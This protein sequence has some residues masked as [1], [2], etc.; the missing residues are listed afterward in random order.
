MYFSD[1]QR[2]L[3]KSPLG[4]VYV[5]YGNN[6][7]EIQETV[8]VLKARAARDDDPAL[9]VVE[10]TKEQRDLADV[11]DALLSVPMFVSSRMVVLQN[12]GDFLNRHRKA[13]EN[14]LE[15]PCE[16]S[17]LVMTVEKWNRKTKLSQRIE[18]LGGDVACWTPRGSQDLIAWV[19]RRAR[20][21]HSKQMD[22]AAAQLLADLCQGDLSGIA[23]ELAKLELYVGTAEAVTEADVSAVGMGYSA[24]R[25]FD[26]CDTLADGNRAAA[27]GVV[28]A[29]MA[30]GLPPPVLVG[31]LRSTFRRLLDTRLAADRDGMTAAVAKHAWNPRDR[32]D[33]RRRVE[34]F[35]ADR[36]VAAYRRLL[37]ADL[38]AKTSRYPDR[39]IVERLLL[40][41][42][43]QALSA[44]GT[45]EVR[46]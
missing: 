31:A 25:P 42:S 22:A 39:L 23:A 29:L 34:R 6:T 37:V 41:L 8:A 18:Q 24:Y 9:A 7:F 38:E 17:V 21:V 28:E 45:D 30:E 26:L 15:R 16:S 44:G 35:S 4:P 11:M 14:Y 36:L 19:Q 12:A 2:H 1:L 43:S 3:A 40:A 10:F 32:D 27:L 5:A 33:L 46:S 20:A 13:L